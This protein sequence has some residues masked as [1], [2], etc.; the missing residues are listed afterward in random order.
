MRNAPG[1]WRFRKPLRS[2][3]TATA[4]RIIFRRIF[5]VLRAVPSSTRSDSG[6]TT[7]ARFASGFSSEDP[8]VYPGRT[9]SF[10]RP[11]R[12]F[13]LNETC[14]F[15]AITMLFPFLVARRGKEFDRVT[16]LA[17]AVRR[18]ISPRLVRLGTLPGAL[19]DI[20]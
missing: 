16:E 17:S 20:F 6:R 1:S 19:V 9:I 11:I 10:T 4:W 2:T 5:T 18:S 7:A 15:L 3:T 8:A 12:S 13:M 14:V